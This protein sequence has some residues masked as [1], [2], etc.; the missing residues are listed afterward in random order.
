MRTVQSKFMSV[1]LFS[2][3]FLLSL[4]GCGGG[5]SGGGSGTTISSIAITPATAS[6]ATGATQQFTA[7]AK[8][9]AG[10]TV[11]GVTFTWAS[12]NT[13]VATI[14]SSGL[15][16]GVAAGSANITAKAGGVTSNTSALTVTA[17]A[18]VTGT[19][20]KG[21]AIGGA[22]ITLVDS[23]GKTATATTAADGTFT[24]DTSGLTPPFM[25]KV[26]AGSTTLY[27]VS[28]DANASTVINVTPLTDLVI[29]SWYSVQGNTV[30]SG[31]S[32]PAT[33]PPPSPTEVKIIGNVVVQVM[34][35]WL[36]NAG[37]DTSATGFSLI[38]TPFTADGT[39]LD[40]VLDE[41]T[42]NS[43]T[44]AISITD[45][46]TTQNST[47]TY[48]TSTGSVNVD[49]TTTG[50]GGASSSSTGTTIP[51][52]SAQ[53]SAF[54]AITAMLNTFAGIVNTKGAALTDTDILPYLD[55]NL[56]NE[57]LDQAQFAASVATQFRGVTVSFAVESIA[58]L[59]TTNGIADVNFT[60]TQ[61]QGSASQTQQT[62]F[63]FK[64]QT[65]GSWLLYGDQRVA[66]PGITSEMRINQG[67]INT[68]SGPD[69][70]VDIRPLQGI[71]RKS[72]V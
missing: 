65:D 59:D 7:V 4:S 58:S 68:G 37:V 16:T 47:V 23:A 40:Q 52:S 57:G 42:I 67:A 39:G 9:S 36:Q 1:L 66:K 28:A 21:T 12:S 17:P 60:L 70:N 27:S 49:T 13:G 41:T 56:L 19:A 50:T 69:I 22:T 15:A 72:V 54:D 20:A 63:Y 31:F 38:S 45:G 55:A 25:V 48:D 43:S 29:R 64:Q 51:I 34:Q 2:S 33:D 30:D 71:D 26:V 11:S 35:L 53:Q 46:T 6:V 61:T 44:G 10:A 18:S 8:D 14:S 24:L 62:E 5:S 3:V 32:K